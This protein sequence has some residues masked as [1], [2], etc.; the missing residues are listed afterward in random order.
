MNKQQLSDQ[1]KSIKDSDMER[2]TTQLNEKMN[3]L[4]STITNLENQ[5]ATLQSQLQEATS[6]LR[7]PNAP[8]QTVQNH[9]RLLHDYNEIR[10]IGQGL[11]SLI[12]EKR[13][14]RYKDVLEEFGVDA[15][16]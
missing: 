14:V 15:N 16:D 11:L 7:S 9:I 12:A 8:S 4:Q 6:K 1:A 13:G 2:H 10:D 5:I 3:S